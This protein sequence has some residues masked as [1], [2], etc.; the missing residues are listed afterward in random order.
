MCC[1]A[2]GKMRDHMARSG[3]CAWWAPSSCWARC[4]T[5]KAPP[6]GQRGETRA[7]PWGLASRHSKMLAFKSQDKGHVDPVGF[8]MQ[9]R[10]GLNQRD[11]ML[12]LPQ[13]RCQPRCSMPRLTVFL[14]Y[15]HARPPSG[16]GASMAQWHCGGSRPAPTRVLR[17]N[18]GRRATGYRAGSEHACGHTPWRGAFVCRRHA[19]P[20]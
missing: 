16:L 2:G 5:L 11:I 7:G 8:A 1:S 20:T 18:I 10:G 6:Q 3:G 9:P 12:R 15:K 14:V 13:K 19:A 17:L 4:A